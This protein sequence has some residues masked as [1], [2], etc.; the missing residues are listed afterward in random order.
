MDRKIT[1]RMSIAVLAILYVVGAVG[2]GFDVIPGLAA[3]T[4]LH[5]FITFLFLVY[6]HEKKGVFFWLWLM[7]A[8]ILGTAAEYFGVKTGLLFGDYEYGA[9]MHPLI[10]GTP[11]IIGVNWIIL[12]YCFTRIVARW[13][14]RRFSLFV[15]AAISA[16]LMTAFDVLIEPVAIELNFWSWEK[17][18]VPL[19]NYAGWWIVSLA[20][21]FL[22]VKM[23]VD[24]GKNPIAFWVLVFQLFFFIFVYTVRLTTQ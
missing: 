14:P 21:N 11:V 19:T 10:D 9:N 15:I 7:T 24:E 5:L 16:T 1:F 2:I 13:A 22:F 17:G 8:Y 4:S 18:Y 6:W 20:L 3:L 23:G 12:S